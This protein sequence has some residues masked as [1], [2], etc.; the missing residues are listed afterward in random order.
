MISLGRYSQSWPQ[1]RPDLSGAYY[2]SDDRMRGLIW[3]VYCRGVELGLSGEEALEDAL[4][5]YNIPIPDRKRKPLPT[6]AGAEEYEQIIQAQ[7]AAK[8]CQET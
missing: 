8:A 1:E 6:D 2:S 7:E 4:D 3:S 5:Y